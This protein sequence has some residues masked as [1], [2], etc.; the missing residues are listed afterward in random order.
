MLPRGQRN[1]NPGNLDYN[2]KNKWVGQVGI[3][4][5]VPKPRFA[6]F[7]TPENGIRALTKLLLNYILRHKLTTIEAI[8]NRYAPTNENF[9]NGYIQA[10]ET[11][12]GIGKDKIDPANYEQMYALVIA[13]IR[14]ELGTQPYHTGIIRE[15]MRLAGFNK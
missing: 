6:R 13:I 15:G 8:I 9:T 7:D 3:E 11:W 4:Q 1:N 2:P 14:K 5:G 12:T 10:V